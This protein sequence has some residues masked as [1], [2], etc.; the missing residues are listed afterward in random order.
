[1]WGRL[2]APWLCALA[3][4][5]LPGRAV[6]AAE[7]PSA[8]KAIVSALKLDPGLLAGMDD[9]A[10]LPPGWREKA[11]QEGALQIIGSWDPAQ[12]EKMTKPFHERYPEVRINYVRGGT[13]DREV[14]TLM[15]FKAGR[16]VAD[17]VTSPGEKWIDFENAGGVED[18]SVMPNFKRL[19]AIMREPNGKWVGERLSYRCMAYNTNRVKKAEL[20]A[21]WDDLIKNTS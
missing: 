6:V 3:A 14:K 2:L 8:T 16:Y 19:D 15:G 17:I 20:P 13:Y 21:T 12:F 1:M 5:T 11:R 18:L 7:L 4:L 10:A 9:E